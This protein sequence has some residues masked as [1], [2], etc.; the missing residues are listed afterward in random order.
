[1]PLDIGERYSGSAL[2][3]GI[4][5]DEYH[6]TGGMS[7]DENVLLSTSVSING[8][9]LELETPSAGAAP[10]SF[11]IT[12]FRSLARSTPWKEGTGEVAIT[13]RPASWA[14]IVIRGANAAA[15]A[16]IA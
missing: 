11:R 4:V 2:S 10:A 14:F 5:V 16:T 9:P 8:H 15:C 13:V 1:M 3:G 7:D 12:D 6:G